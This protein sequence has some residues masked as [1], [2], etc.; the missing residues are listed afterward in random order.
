MSAQAS[1]RIQGTRYYC[2][3]AATRDSISNA[4]YRRLPWCRPANGSVPAARLPPPQQPP[5]T[6]TPTSRR[7]N[8]RRCTASCAS[9]EARP[10]YSTAGMPRLR[11]GDRAPQPA[12]RTRAPALSSAAPPVLVLLSALRP[13]SPW[14]LLFSRV[15]QTV[16]ISERGC[17]LAR[18]GHRGTAAEAK[19]TEGRS[20]C[21]FDD[22]GRGTAVW[23][24]EP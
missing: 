12:P 13:L 21:R 16:S 22:D 7:S 17:A 1:C 6:P 3:I 20:P 15:G 18:A 10:I 14:Q 9:W 4:W 5:P 11:C 8:W 24:D 2:A 23:H 19:E